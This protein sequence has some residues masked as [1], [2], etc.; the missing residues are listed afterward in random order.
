[1]VVDA[2]DDVPLFQELS[3]RAVREMVRVITTPCTSGGI[4]ECFTQRFSEILHH[5]ASQVPS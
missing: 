5:D 4:S 2:Q 1:V 3:S